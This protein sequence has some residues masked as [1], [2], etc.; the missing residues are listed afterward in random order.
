MA[1]LCDGSEGHHLPASEWDMVC[2]WLEVPYVADFTLPVWSCLRRQ[3]ATSHGLDVLGEQP[4]SAHVLLYFASALSNTTCGPQQALEELR[5]AITRT[6]GRFTVSPDL[7]LR[8]LQLFAAQEQVDAPS[9]L[10]YFNGI[11]PAHRTTEAYEV[12]LDA[13]SKLGLADDAR[14]VSAEMRAHQEPGLSQE[15]VRIQLQQLTDA[16]RKTPRDSAEHAA[17]LQEGEKWWRESV[18]RA[19]V[20][21][22]SGNVTRDMLEFLR[23]AGGPLVAD[24]QLEVY[25]E[26]LSLE[27]QHPLTGTWDAPVYIKPHC[28]SLLINAFATS[29]RQWR[30]GAQAE[31]HW[32]IVCARAAEAESFCVPVAK[33]SPPD[34]AFRRR[35]QTRISPII[36]ATFLK[37]FSLMKNG[38]LVQ[39]VWAATSDEEKKSNPVMFAQML[40]YCALT[41]DANSAEQLMAEHH[42]LGIPLSLFVAESW[43]A[44]HVH[45][46]DVAAVDR[47]WAQMTEAG[48]AS[49]PRTFAIAMSVRIQASV[50]DDTIGPEIDR[51]LEQMRTSLGPTAR[52]HP[53][54]YIGLMSAARYA[55]QPHLRIFWE[56]H[57]KAAGVALPPPTRRRHRGQ[58]GPGPRNIQ[59]QR[60]GDRKNV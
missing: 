11:L 38:P 59:H 43:M 25:E 17:L 28:T 46:G 29:H 8:M 19:D 13:L 23:Y 27:Q 31:K 49:T 5:W 54:D 6:S 15:T 56:N 48:I 55:C 58:Q 12:V 22:P 2:R 4:L 50:R 60:T 57:A 18:L 14:A 21:L 41:S 47:V 20:L 42:Q 32:R 39:E 24:R 9:M 1:I 37:Y 53:N 45:A 16:I 34:A 33:N 40:N 7:H 36:R 35:R 10:A 26:A 3:M 52:F 44:A 30:W 51:L